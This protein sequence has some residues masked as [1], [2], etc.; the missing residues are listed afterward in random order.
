MATPSAAKKP[1]VA[2]AYTPAIFR[3]QGQARPG[4]GFE[5]EVGVGEAVE[6][7][8]GAPVP[9]GADTVV[10]V[11]VTAR[12][13]DQI[14]VLEAVPVGRHV[15][16][17]G[18]DIV[19]GTTVLPT[20]RV[21]RPQDVGV[22]SGLGV[23]TVTV[24][25]QPIVTIVITG[26]EL[27]PPGTPPAGYQFADM[28]SPMLTALVQRDGGMVRTSWAPFRTVATRFATPFSRRLRANGHGP[29]LGR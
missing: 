2:A 1:T 16:R 6:I 23:G 21:L 12:K 10:P 8:T 5:G 26:D 28:N 22:L 27:L 11:E 7:A 29:R 24:V 14:S 20:G 4:R 25:R 15:G 3:C 19:A 18:E 17:V 9:A 13:G